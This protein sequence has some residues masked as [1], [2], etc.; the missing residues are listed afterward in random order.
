MRGVPMV[1]N[2]NVD[3]LCPFRGTQR[4][5]C[6]SS[7]PLLCERTDVHPDNP[8]RYVC[9]LNPVDDAIAPKF[10]GKRM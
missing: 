4:P 5:D 8:Y 10:M 6:T 7:C 1:T 3:M 9:G 2:N